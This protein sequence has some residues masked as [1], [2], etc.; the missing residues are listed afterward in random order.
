M[1]SSPKDEPV[2]ASKL[3][4]ELSMGID[5]ISDEVELQLIQRA[6]EFAL[7]R[8][9][10]Q[11]RESGEPFLSH[12]VAVAQ[13]LIEFRLDPATICAG[14]LHHIVEQTDTT[15]SEIMESFGDEISGLIHGITK[16]PQ[17]AFLTGETYQSENFRKMLFASARD[18]R[19]IFIKL[20]DRLHNMR[21]LKYLSI[22]KQQRIAQETLE[23]YAPLANRL[24]M[25]TMKWELEDLAFRYLEPDVYQDIRKQVTRK[26]CEREKDIEQCRKLIEE[27]LR[28]DG[29]KVEVTGRPKHFYSIYQKMK[30]Q[31]IGL[32]Q[33]YDLAGI[34]IICL[35]NEEKS[36]YHALGIIH[37]LWQPI[38]YRFKDFISLPK[39]NMYQ[40]IHSTVIGP[41]GMPLEIQIRTR[42]MDRIAEVGI[43]AHWKY[44]EVHSPMAKSQQHYTWLHQLVDWMQEL[45]DPRDF[46]PHFKIDLFPDE[47]YVFTPK[48]EV[49]FL[50]RGATPIDFAYQVHSELGRRCVGAKVNGRIVPLSYRLESGDHLEILTSAKHYPSQDWLTFV[51]TPKARSKIKKDIHDRHRQASIELGRKLLGLELKKHKLT[52]TRFLKDHRDQI[53][54]LLTRFACRKPDDFFVRIGLGTINPYQA[55][56][57]IIETEETDDAIESSARVSP[58]DSGP[59]QIV[60]KMFDH[61]ISIKVDGLDHMLINF[62]RCCN[63]VPGDDIIGF[64]TRGRGLTIHTRTCANIHSVKNPEH[65]LIDVSWKYDQPAEFTVRLKIMARDRKGLFA[66]TTAT[67]T[68][69]DSN[70]LSGQMGVQEDNNEV[71][72]VFL[73]QVKNTAHLNRIIAA[74]NK[75]KGITKIIRLRAQH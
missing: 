4:P 13:L 11:K 5:Y 49:R 69:L 70:I 57:K 51:K 47:I 32:D 44:K 37:T 33:I 34:R 1:E 56:Q 59:D 9:Q 2:T 73:L 28:E 24:G 42:E 65:R 15:E 63:P 31:Q 54:A 23:I 21:T 55:L 39:A 17:S 67:I 43:A 66:D 72:G 62:A 45:E 61:D 48:A 46:M 25:A 64:I 12:L 14:L 18:L 60:K 7:E 26:R 41:G 74:L 19:I 27:K 22:T 50:P 36:C 52:L 35:D 29:L 20:A 53:E 16:L 40:S 3:V 58:T 30:R 6:Y 68:K 10:D 75:V 38:N 8:H 71:S